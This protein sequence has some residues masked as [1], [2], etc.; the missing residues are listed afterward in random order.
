MSRR[1]IVRQ[2]T[3]IVGSRPR[4]EP[5]ESKV[6]Q[7]YAAW[8]PKALGHVVSWGQTCCWRVMRVGSVHQFK[9]VYG[10]RSLQDAMKRYTVGWRWFTLAREE[11][12][13]KH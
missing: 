1:V 4:E 7:V 12:M 13:V 3:G 5:G 2:Y 11:R 10:T 9:T 8:G 6:K